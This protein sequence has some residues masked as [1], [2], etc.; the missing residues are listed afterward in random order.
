MRGDMDMATRA[1]LLYNAKMDGWQL[2]AAVLQTAVCHMQLYRRAKIK[3]AVAQAEYEGYMHASVHSDKLAMIR[4]QF[5]DG[6]LFDVRRAAELA[7]RIS[8]LQ[9]EAQLHLDTA[10]EAGH[11]IRSALL[12]SR[13]AKRMC[14]HA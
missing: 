7:M 5:G 1:R 13:E 2:F 4:G 12:Q 10:Y 6:G 3:L 8:S 11:M 9:I 14:H